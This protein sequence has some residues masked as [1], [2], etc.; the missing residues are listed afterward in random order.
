[1]NEVTIHYANPK[2]LSEPTAVAA[3]I[4]QLNSAHVHSN[5]KAFLALDGIQ[6]NGMES[7]YPR[8][9]QYYMIAIKNIKYVRYFSSVLK[10][11]IQKVKLDLSM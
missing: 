4:Q 1:M 5:K 6:M 9:T 8:I 7:F 2:R 3:E 10:L 11:V